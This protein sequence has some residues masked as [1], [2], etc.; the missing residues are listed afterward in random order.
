[1]DVPLA[2]KKLKNNQYFGFVA[3]YTFLQMKVHYQRPTISV[4][5]CTIWFRKVKK[6][7]KGKSEKSEKV[8]KGKSKLIESLK[9]FYLLPFYPFTLFVIAGSDGCRLCCGRRFHCKVCGRCDK[10]RYVHLHNARHRT[11]G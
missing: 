11:H 2:T 4:T 3:F 1:M 6:G 5:D 9:P 10:E 7:S 8:F